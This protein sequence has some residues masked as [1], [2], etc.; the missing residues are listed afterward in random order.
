MY[1]LSFEIQG[2]PK[3]PNQLLRKHWSVV[4]KNANQWKRLVGLSTRGKTPRAPL[5]LAQLTLIRFG[6]RLMDYDGLVTSFKPVVDGL[7]ESQVIEDDSW[8][9]VGR[10]DV[11]QFKVSKGEEKIVV[12]VKE[13][14][15]TR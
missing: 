3:T 11:S 13:V 9:H 1:E 8:N 14:S 4:S 5:P 10:W 15:P 2:L 7:I 6:T 12:K